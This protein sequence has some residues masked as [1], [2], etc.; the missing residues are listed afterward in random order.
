MQKKKVLF[1]SHDGS[2]SGAPRS[3]AILV[4][5]FA[6]HTDWDIRVLC[7]GPGPLVRELGEN[8]PVDI[9][10]EFARPKARIPSIL[11]NKKITNERKVE[12]INK[13]VEGIPAQLK[14]EEKLV[15]N[16]Q[17]WKPDF[18]YS[19]TAVNGEELRQLNIKVP[20][21]VHVRELDTSLNLMSPIASEEFQV[22]PDYYLAVSNAVKKNLIKRYQFN[23]D[24]IAIAP[25]ALEVEKTLKLA[26]KIS[27]S[28]IRERYEIPREARI[29]GGIGY[30]NHRKGPDIFY[31]IAS[32][33]I[34]NHDDD[35]VFIWAGDGTDIDL[36]RDQII[37]DNIGDRLK[38]VGL[39]HEIY[40]LIKQFDVFLMTSRDDP[41]PRVN[42]ESGLF[43]CPVIAFEESGGSCEY[44]E[45]DAGISVKGF[46]ASSMSKALDEL[47]SNPEKARQLGMAGGEKVKRLYDISVVGKKVR[48]IIRSR[49]NI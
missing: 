25:V 15:K 13:E 14:H 49:Y 17:D 1:V 6:K 35:V 37:K 36:Y 31:Q 44:I 3:L 34:K 42:M 39:V 38:F 48:E 10:Y 40:P 5:Y 33:W 20:H 8:F 41:F 7:V 43:N 32:E 22:R 30:V 26:D 27:E 29:V 23:P 9:W 45:D 4:G 19:N 24:K 28:E 12:L 16:L 2:V 11:N 18:I 46:E 47:L 21:L